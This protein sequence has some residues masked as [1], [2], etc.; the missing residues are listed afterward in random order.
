MADPKRATQVIEL[1]NKNHDS[2]RIMFII[3][4]EYHEKFRQLNA[5]YEATPEQF[6]QL[7]WDY[8]EVWIITRN[9]IYENLFAM[10][11]HTTEDEWKDLMKQ[12]KKYLNQRI[13][14]EY[15]K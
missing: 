14:N 6:K 13:E 7:Y 1:I 11:N 15:A 5:D 3:S 8:D 2:F 9:H 12:F 10:K 4:Q